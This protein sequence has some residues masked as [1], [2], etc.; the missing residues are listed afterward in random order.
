MARTDYYDDPDAPEP[1]SIVPA[2]VACI[3]D[4]EGRLLLEHR[5]DNDL[6][7]LPGGTHEFGESIVQTI[8]RE[9]REETGLDVE[10]AGL[11]GIYT[12][13]RALIAYSDGEVRQQFT[14]SFRC[15]V[16]GGS[17]EKDSES[18]ELRWVEREAL[19]GLTIHPSMRL[20]IDHFLDEQES[21]YLG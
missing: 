21:P 20:R 7:A 2:A 8:V 15:R 1:N 18:H 12:D 13:P 5:V 4:D 17:L 3:T 6:W 11:V 19:D 10:V 9:V 16:L 14:L